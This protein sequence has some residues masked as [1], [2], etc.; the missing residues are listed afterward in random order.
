MMMEEECSL[1]ND[2]GQ[3][4]QIVLAFLVLIV[5][6]LEY[7]WERICAW[8]NATQEKRDMIQFVYD[9]F[10][11]SCGS[12]V[13][14][15]FNV[16]VS[17]WMSANSA[18]G[19]ECGLYAIAFVYE[20]SGVCFVQLQMYC[21]IKFAESRSFVSPNWRIIS[22]PGQ[23]NT[24]WEDISEE[25][26][27]SSTFW[28]RIFISVVLSL[29]SLWIGLSLSFSNAMTFI[30][31]VLVFFLS[32]LFLYTSFEARLQTVAWVSIK[33]FEK[34][35][36]SMF[37]IAQTPFFR[38]WSLLMGIKGHPELEAIWYICLIPMII[39]SI[40]FYF[41]SKI[42]RL[43]L[44][45]VSVEERSNV[46]DQFFDLQEAVQVGIVFSVYMNLV[47]WIFCCIALRDW[48]V[49]GVLFVSIVM[50]P[51]AMAIIFIWIG[52]HFVEKSYAMYGSDQKLNFLNENEG[53]DRNF[54]STLDTTPID[55][56]R[57]K[58]QENLH[59]DGQP[60]DMAWGT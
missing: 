60:A 30:G 56:S 17:M 8:W 22:K 42:S 26:F 14:H 21:L 23:Y 16:L 18:L 32:F 49:V 55:F 34:S 36:W 59:K 43:E 35:I 57:N 15:L 24:K 11:I 10:K 27:P 47:I 38:R 48:E 6:T 2:I 13:S 29:G 53:V 52:R 40:I 4:T 31:P 39:N 45:C 41:L 51:V 20:A 3:T 1:T 5:L 54:N 7:F 44:P 25:F 28:L 9:V 19:N 46:E 37:A 33:A 58:Y 12:A 50:L